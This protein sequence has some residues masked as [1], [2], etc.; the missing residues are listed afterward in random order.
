MEIIDKDEQI[1]KDAIKRAKQYAPSKEETGY[2]LGYIDGYGQ[3][4]S[5]YLKQIEEKNKDIGRIQARRI[6][7]TEEAT[8]LKQELQEA[9]KLLQESLSYINSGGFESINVLS[10]IHKNKI[11]EF[12]NK[13]T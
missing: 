5:I 6:E 4:E 12:L 8:R 11:Q 7:I 3:S 2:T 1:G 13:N 10:K 9:K